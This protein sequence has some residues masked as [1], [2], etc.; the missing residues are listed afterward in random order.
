VKGRIESVS[1][2]HPSRACAQQGGAIFIAVCFKPPFML[3]PL[4]HFLLSHGE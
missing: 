2:A 4:G 3:D 1:C